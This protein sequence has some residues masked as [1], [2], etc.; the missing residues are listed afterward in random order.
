MDV[1]MSVGVAGYAT[2]SR[3]LLQEEV[4]CIKHGVLLNYIHL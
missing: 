3:I 4:R 1:V 2:D